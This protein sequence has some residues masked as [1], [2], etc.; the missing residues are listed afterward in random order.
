[1]KYPAEPDCKREMVNITNTLTS[2][3]NTDLNRGTLQQLH[4]PVQEAVDDLEAWGLVV[5]DG[6]Q[7]PLVPSLA[8]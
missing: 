4:H 3:L 7:P 6:R 5:E 2:L 8:E 1:M